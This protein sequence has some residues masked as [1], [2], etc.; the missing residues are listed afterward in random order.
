MSVSPDD[1]P[2][3]DYC[4]EGAMDE[5]DGWRHMRNAPRDGSRVLVTIRPTE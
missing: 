2:C 4:K 1:T 5:L 3:V